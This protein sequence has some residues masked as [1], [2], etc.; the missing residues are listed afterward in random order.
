MIGVMGVKR[1][2][3]EYRVL[4]IRGCDRGLALGVRKADRLVY[5][6][7]AN[8]L[9]IRAVGYDRAWSRARKASRVVRKA[10]SE[11]ELRT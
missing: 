11:D 9:S 7:E 4:R 5:E 8:T 1:V 2:I 6:T 10:D 3:S